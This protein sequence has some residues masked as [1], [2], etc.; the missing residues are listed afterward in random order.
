M[1]QQQRRE[2]QANSNVL[3]SS[4]FKE[5]NAFELQYTNMDGAVDKTKLNV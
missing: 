3:S 2:G 4:V 1:Y 5:M